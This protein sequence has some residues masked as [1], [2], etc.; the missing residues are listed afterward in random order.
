MCIFR[1]SIDQELF[2]TLLAQYKKLEEDIVALAGMAEGDCYRQ[3]LVE[4]FGFERL[5][6]D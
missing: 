2:S 4:R 6:P 5:E 3:M 1:L